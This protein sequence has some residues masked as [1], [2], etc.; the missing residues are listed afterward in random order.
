MSTPENA[1]SPEQWPALLDRRRNPTLR[2]RF[3]RAERV[4]RANNPRESFQAACLYGIRRLQQIYPGVPRATLASVVETVL[5]V[6]RRRPRLA[7]VPTVLRRPGPA[8]RDD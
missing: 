5:K 2:Q 6:R 4:L 1:S 7:R 8:P 3:E